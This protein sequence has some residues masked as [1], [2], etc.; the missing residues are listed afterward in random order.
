MTRQNHHRGSG[1]LTSLLIISQTNIF[2]FLTSIMT[3]F[4][5]SAHLEATTGEGLIVIN[6]IQ[7][8]TLE[9]KL[10]VLELGIMTAIV[11][12]EMTKKEKV[13]RNN[14]VEIALD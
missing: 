1:W 8:S 11:S 13:W 4:Q 12:S 14:Y 5:I 2:Q 3:L 10:E 6:L 9:E 7:R